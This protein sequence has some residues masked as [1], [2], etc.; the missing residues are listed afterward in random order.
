MAPCENSDGQYDGVAPNAKIAFVD[1]GNA[2]GNLMSLPPQKLYSPGRT[3]GARIHTNSW[4]GYY[5]GDQ[6]YDGAAID[7]YLFN[8]QVCQLVQM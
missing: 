4:G 3:A 6:F 7:D 1:L 5:S 2:K 8:N